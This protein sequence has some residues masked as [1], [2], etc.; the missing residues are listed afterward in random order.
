M[1]DTMKN[2][3]EVLLSKGL[4]YKEENMPVQLISQKCLEGAKGKS[5]PRN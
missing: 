4:E 1:P 2:M 3:V 5:G